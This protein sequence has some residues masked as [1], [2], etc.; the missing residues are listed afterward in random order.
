MSEEENI[1]EQSIKVEEVNENISSQDSIE[2]TE[3]SDINPSKI[4]NME[5]HHHPHVEKKNF[6]DYFLEFVMIFLAVTLGFI[7]ENIREDIT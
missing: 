3:T 5:V 7:A 6:K 2:Q 1:P 4:Q